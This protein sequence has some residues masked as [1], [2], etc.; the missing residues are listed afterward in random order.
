MK[1]AFEGSVRRPPAM[2]FVTRIQIGDILH[3]LSDV[4]GSA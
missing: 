3:V 2:A 4:C 1:G